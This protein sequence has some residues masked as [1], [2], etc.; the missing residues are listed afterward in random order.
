M[1]TWTEE[2]IREYYEDELEPIYCPFCIKRGYE[3]RLGPKILMP[4][5][6]RDEDYENWLCCSTCYVEI[7]IYQVEPEPTI[8][9]TVE[10]IDN[11]FEQG[12]LH[13]ETIPK[14]NSPAGKNASAKKRR[15]KIKPTNDEEINE[16]K[17]R[18]GDRVNVVMDT[19]P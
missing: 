3:I 12:K 15:N 14:R 10:T 4:G 11:P 1:K 17:R 6:V 5:Q 16:E 8:K 13:L 18:H 7:P 9:N 19:N 2:E